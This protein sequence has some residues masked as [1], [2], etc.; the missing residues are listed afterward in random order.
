MLIEVEA[1]TPD[2]VAMRIIYLFSLNLLATS[3]YRVND[4]AS[5]K[6]PMAQTIRLSQ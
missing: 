2:W 4:V 6:N 5:V 3:Q 1:K